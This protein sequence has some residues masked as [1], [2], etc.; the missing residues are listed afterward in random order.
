MLRVIG[1]GRP[2]EGGRAGWLP[3]KVLPRV[4]GLSGRGLSGGGG[5]LSSPPALAAFETLAGLVCVV[6][7]WFCSSMPGGMP[8]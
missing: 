4:V 1:E 7:M 3:T 2:F 8:G 6:F 5:G